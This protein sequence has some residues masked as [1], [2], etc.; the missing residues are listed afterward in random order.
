MLSTS[1]LHHSEQNSGRP[2][3]CTRYCTEEPRNACAASAAACCKVSGGPHKSK[4]K[5]LMLCG[6]CLPWHS[7]FTACNK[8]QHMDSQDCIAD[9]A[10]DVKTLHVHCML[11]L[12]V[13]NLAVKAWSYIGRP[14]W[15][16]WLMTML[17]KQDHCTLQG[18]LWQRA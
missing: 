13:N 15:S 17:G 4:G 9:F 16:S 10:I 5:S 1:S 18:L 8:P 2:A 11:W 12:T 3:L 6:A 14:L 7:S